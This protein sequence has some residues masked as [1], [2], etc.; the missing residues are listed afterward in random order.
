MPSSLAHL[1]SDR[2]TRKG[3]RLGTLGYIPGEGDGAELGFQGKENLIYRESDVLQIRAK[4]VNQ[5]CWHT[6]RHTQVVLRRGVKPGSLLQ[7]G[8][9]QIQRSKSEDLNEN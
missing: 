6:S 2:E 9:S 1:W 4:S 3:L 8:G 7:N 5:L